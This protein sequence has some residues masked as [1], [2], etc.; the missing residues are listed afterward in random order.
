MKTI[1]P[2]ERLHP[3]ETKCRFCKNTIVVKINEEGVKFWKDPDNLLKLAACNECA[4]YMVARRNFIDAI[5]KTAWVIVAAAEGKRDKPTERLRLLLSK[6][7]R[8]IG[9]R[10]HKPPPSS[11]G[12]AEKII[13]TP[14][15]AKFIA[16]SMEGI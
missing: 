7:A 1:Q 15:R 8:A 10:L 12:L 3:I 6:F 14:E 4:D 5:V 9:D 2:T 16:L 13:E 11:Y